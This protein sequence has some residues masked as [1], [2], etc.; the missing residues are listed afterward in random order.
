MSGSLYTGMRAPRG[1]FHLDFGDIGVDYSA[2]TKALVVAI[3]GPSGSLSLTSWT[4][5]ATATSLRA[6]FLLT[7][8][9]FTAPGTHNFS[10]VLT[11]NGSPYDLV[12]WT[13]YVHE[14]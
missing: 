11:L 10:G 4:W 12:S 9:E 3:T 13:D 7:G 14:N 2:A 1:L 8:S 6:T 5:T